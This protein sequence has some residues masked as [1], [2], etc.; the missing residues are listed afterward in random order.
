MQAWSILCYSLTAASITRWS[1]L[2]DVHAAAA[3]TRPWFGS[4]KRG[5]AE[6]PTLPSR[7]VLD[8][9]WWMAT[10]N[11]ER[12]SGIICFSRSTVCD[13]GKW[14]VLGISAS[15]FTRYSV[16]TECMWGGS[17]CKRYVVFYWESV[18]E[19]TLKLG[20]HFCITYDQKDCINYNYNKNYNIYNN[21]HDVTLGY[22][23]N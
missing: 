8:L 11:A 15:N 16:A 12:S 6:S 20:L 19:N 7:W 4:C 21:S 18:G 17:F 5:L 22:S 14:R 3:L 23:E 9:G 1:R 10:E 13:A 2:L